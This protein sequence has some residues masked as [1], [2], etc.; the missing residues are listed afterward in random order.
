VWL[1]IGKVGVGVGCG[2]K[3]GGGRQGG[4]GEDAGG[5][6]RR[7]RERDLVRSCSPEQVQWLS[8]FSLF[9]ATYTMVVAFF[10]VAI[11][12]QESV[13]YTFLI[14]ANLEQKR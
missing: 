12:A 3:W 9:S 14:L 5:R 1:I 2:V 6:R 11:I 7:R 4:G 10:Q 8:L 13:C